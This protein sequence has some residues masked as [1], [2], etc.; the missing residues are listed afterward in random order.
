MTETKT[1]TEAEAQYALEEPRRL[2]Q[3]RIWQLQRNFFEQQGHAAWGA[4]IVPSYITTNPF[5]ANAYA[6]VVL[7]FLRDCADV[8]PDETEFP[9]LDLMQPVYVVELGA[10]AGR[11]AFNFLSKFGASL[12]RAVLHD[13]PFKYVMTDLA[14][15][16][17]DFWVSHPALQPFVESGRLD[18][19]L[20]DAE[21]PAPLELWHSG[22]VLDAGTVA[23]P[24][25]LLA[26]YFFDSIP[27][28]AFYVEA[29]KLN[30]S[31]LK[32]ASTQPE[33][34]SDDPGLF[35]RVT[36]IYERQPVTTDYYDDPDLNRLLE[37]YRQSLDQTALDFPTAAL[38]CIRFFRA[39][40]GDRLLLLGGDKGYNRAEDLNGRQEPGYAVHGSFSM[41][42]NYHAIGQY[43]RN[44]GGQA[45]E[46][47]YRYS[48]LNIL[49]F[50]LGSHPNG[51]AE[52]RHAFYEAIEKHGPDDY[53]NLTQGFEPHVAALKLEQLLAHLRFS[54]WDSH[55]FLKCFPVLLEQVGAADESQK[56]ELHRAIEALRENY[57][58]VGEDEDVLFDL[59]MLLDKLGAPAQAVG[60]FEE[61]LRL[62][63]PAPSTFYNK[64][65]CHFRLR[66]LDRALSDVQQALALNPEFEQAQ[67]LLKAIQVETLRARAH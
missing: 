29:G 25:V 6:Q 51:F 63:G 43:F 33:P 66:Q 47:S 27:Q 39:L 11:F 13:L 7:G 48:G 1:A 8:A 52:T 26:N 3:S 41:Q 59:G 64:A 37:S 2:S 44:A 57:Y 12:A 32:L 16:N 50:L 19:A 60:Y 30:E 5:I 28:D 14:A 55:I 21:H 34:D 17:L 24:V 22:E 4:G 67:K 10:G 38:A 9:P 23:N 58:Y 35:R 49:G 36:L 65:V 46:M 54:G 42:V 56:A 18:F 40:G 53:F 31:W 20:F 62:C 45:L 15:K 61:S